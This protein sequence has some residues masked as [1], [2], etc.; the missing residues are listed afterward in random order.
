MD[1]IRRAHVSDISDAVVRNN[2]RVVKTLGDGVMSS[3]ESALGA[4]RAAAAI[5]AAVEPAGRR[6]SGWRSLG[7]GENLEGEPPHLPP[8]PG[9]S[10]RPAL[11]IW[12]TG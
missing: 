6:L 1:E 5:Q 9:H 4:L 7:L 2:G 8:N 10:K 12:L 11:G 3:L